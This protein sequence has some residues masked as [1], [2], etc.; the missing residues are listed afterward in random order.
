ACRKTRAATPG[1]PPMVQVPTSPRCLRCSP[2][3][4]SAAASR[5]WCGRFARGASVRARSTSSSWDFQSCLDKSGTSEEALQLLVGLLRRLLAWIVP[6]RQRLHAHDVRAVPRP[7]GARLVV[8]AG[9][10]ELAP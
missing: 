3:A 5:S 1:H 7:N 9:V 10:A 6:A 2:P 8:L 4:M